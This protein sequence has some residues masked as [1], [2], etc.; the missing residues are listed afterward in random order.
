MSSSTMI[1][2]C[3]KSNLR[4]W[5]SRIWW[6]VIPWSLCWTKSGK[7]LRSWSPNSLLDNH[8][9]VREY[10]WISRCSSIIR[11]RGRLLLTKRQLMTY[12][13]LYLKSKEHFTLDQL[14][15]F[16]S[17]ISISTA[18]EASWSRK[19]VAQ[20]EEQERVTDAPT[21]SRIHAC[22]TISSSKLNNQ[23]KK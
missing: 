17:R 6:I 18:V 9:Q 23:F 2:I 10:L 4:P 19:G 15:Q 8:W 13:V 1:S 7:T 11:Q 20:Q 12:S 5:S 22:K 16:Q 3:G 21:P 14:T